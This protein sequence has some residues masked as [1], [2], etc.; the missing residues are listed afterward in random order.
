MNF[1][2]SLLIGGESEPF[3]LTRQALG[4]LSLRILFGLFI[5]LHGIDALSE[6]EKMEKLTA[7]VG[8]MGFPAPLF[9]AYCAKLSEAVGGAF[10]ML[11]LF[12]RPACFFLIITMAVATFLAKANKPLMDRELPLLFLVGF[13]VILL[14]GPGKFA[15]DTLL[16]TFWKAK[17]L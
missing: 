2:R 14:V 15:L 9:F 10:V 6:P 4:L 3:Q 17:T 5:M 12:T 8:D 7:S 16:R 11:G 1:V 13:I